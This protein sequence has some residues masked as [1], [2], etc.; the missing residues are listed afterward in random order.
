[1]SSLITIIT[2]FFVP[3]RFLP[4]RFPR[5]SEGF[6]RDYRLLPV[7]GFLFLSAGLI[8]LSKQL[9]FLCLIKMSSKGYDVKIAKWFPFFQTCP[10]LV[11]TL[12]SLGPMLD[13]LGIDSA[14]PPRLMSPF[15][16]AKIMQINKQKFDKWIIDSG[17]FNNFSNSYYHY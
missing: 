13:H 15:S 17:N 5:V 6:P 11:P 1:M 8:W 12:S 3:F 14:G 7:T 2:V 16:A 9:I 4:E 10:F